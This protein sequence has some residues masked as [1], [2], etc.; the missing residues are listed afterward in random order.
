VEAFVRRRIAVNIGH[1]AVVIVTAGGGHGGPAE[2]GGDVSKTR[3]GG[4]RALGLQ[5]LGRLHV[6]PAG[7]GA[8]GCRE[9]GRGGGGRMQTQQL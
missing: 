2:A 9:R 1:G 5:R 7:V 4:V 3:A 6:A 8:G